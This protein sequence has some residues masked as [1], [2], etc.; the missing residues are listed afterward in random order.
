MG[1]EEGEEEA[2]RA[3]R[4]KGRRETCQQTPY[5]VNSIS[6]CLSRLPDPSLV[7]S[8]LRYLL[9]GRH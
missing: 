1:R 4:A 3:E 8:Q 5:L 6:Y 9:P 2:R 7:A